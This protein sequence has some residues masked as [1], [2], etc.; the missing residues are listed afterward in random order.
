MNRS[1]LIQLGVACLAAIALL[2][3]YGHDTTEAMISPALPILTVFGMRLFLHL[4][5]RSTPATETNAS[6]APLLNR[7]TRR[8]MKTKKAQAKDKARISLQSIDRNIL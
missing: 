2:I 3:T 4:R 7:A 5:D 8:A 6:P 1:F